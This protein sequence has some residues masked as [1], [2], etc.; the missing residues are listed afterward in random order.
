[1]KET[2]V[3][4]LFTNQT[5]AASGSA[6]SPVVNMNDYK[7]E[8]D[9]VTFQIHIA[10]AGATVTFTVQVSHDNSQF[11]AVASETQIAA[12]QGPGDV[13]FSFTPPIAPFMKVVATETGGV[14]GVTDLDMTMAIR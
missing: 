14:A 8:R 5:I 7:P 12:D 10:G 6:T 9:K 11:N 13:T 3:V 2:N 1:M 4:R